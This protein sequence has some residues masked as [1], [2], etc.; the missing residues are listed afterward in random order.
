MF[1]DKDFDGDP[2]RVKPVSQNEDLSLIVIEEE[3]NTVTV[4]DEATGEEIVFE[5]AKI[6]YPDG[7][8]LAGNWVA[9]EPNQHREK[10]YV[11]GVDVSVLVSREM[12]FDQHGKPITTSLKDHTKE[13][14]KEKF[15]SL[16]DFLNKWNTTDRKEA[17]IAELQEQ[18]VMVEAL[19][20]AV[21]KQVDLFDLICHVAYD[22]PPLTRKE[23]ANNVKKR[24]YFT[25]YGD[26]ARKVLEALLE[27]YADQ[28]IENIENIQILTV[29]PINEFGS[30][31]EII[32]AFGRREEYEKAIKELENE[33]YKVA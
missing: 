13:I 10:V 6:R 22:K 17:I 4:L 9:K 32:K 30:V 29:P 16:D 23:R 20:E 14:I 27:K 12:Y 18:G 2:I 33:L 11:N 24:N 28:G 1:A 31:T 15:A 8:K 3:E 7:S 21:D 25:K 5:K 26:Q 19:Y